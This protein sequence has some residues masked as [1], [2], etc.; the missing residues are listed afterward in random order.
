[1]ECVSVSVTQCL[2]L[3]LSVLSLNCVVYIASVSIS[4]S[5]SFRLSMVCMCSLYVFFIL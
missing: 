3:P 2:F 4:H 1:M 5:G